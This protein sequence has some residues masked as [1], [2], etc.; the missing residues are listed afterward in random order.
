MYR[1]SAVQVYHVGRT[2]AM[3]LIQEL[4]FIS[5]RVCYWSRQVAL[6]VFSCWVW[7]RNSYLPWV[8]LTL[9]R[10]SQPVSTEAKAK[11]LF[12]CTHGIF[13]RVCVFAVRLFLIGAMRLLLLRLAGVI[14]WSLFDDSPLKPALWK[15]KKKILAGNFL[16]D[17]R[18]LNQNFVAGRCSQSVVFHCVA[19]AYATTSLCNVILFTNLSSH[20]F[21]SNAILKQLVTYD[22]TI[23]PHTC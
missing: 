14:R 4:F 2:A 23:S 15:Q 3:P 19:K 18:W 13:P 12:T 22:P 5:L 20:V 1:K 21:Y 16:S 10:L 9:N 17:S 7:K 6:K 11:P 8:V